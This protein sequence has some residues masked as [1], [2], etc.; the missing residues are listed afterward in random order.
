MRVTDGSRSLDVRWTST[1][2]TIDVHDGLLNVFGQQQYCRTAGAGGG[3]GS[4]QRRD[5][6]RRRKDPSAENRRLGEQCLGV[7]RT[8]A[9]AGVLKATATIHGGRR[10]AHQ[11]Q[12]RYPAGE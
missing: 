2:V 5:D 6:V 10:L 8:V 3:N 1:T 12:H 4:R 11:S 7:Q 9:A